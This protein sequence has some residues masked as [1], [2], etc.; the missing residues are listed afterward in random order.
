MA[1][2][3]A[4]TGIGGFD[5]VTGGGLPA[6]RVTVVVGGPGSGKTL[7]AL[8]TLV[9]GAA[10][11]EEP[12]LFVAFEESPEDVVANASGFGWDLGPDSGVEFLDAQLSQSVIQGG[13]FDLVGLLAILGLRVE[14]LGAKRVVF[15]GIDVLLALLGDPELVRRECF[16][17]RSWL[18]ESGLTGILTAKGDAASA[19]LSPEYDFLQ[20]MAD[21]VITLHQRISEG[22][23]L[24][25]IRVAKY[26]GS[27]HSGNEIP[28]VFAEQGIELAAEG[29][30]DLHH[31]APTERISTGIARLDHMLQGGYLRASS[32]LV[33]GAPGTAKTS[34][35]A[36]FVDAAAA[37]G[38]RALYVSFDEAPE[39]IVRNVASIGI[40]LRQWLDAGL[41]TMVSMRT[42]A[43]NPEFLV[44]RMRALLADTNAS[45]MVI[46][47]LSALSRAGGQAAAERAALAVL[48]YAKSLS[49]TVL[50][51]S[52]LGNQSPLVEETPIA[53]S[54][55]ADTWM[56][57]TYLNQGGERNRALT[58]IKSR[59]TSHSS[60]VRELLLTADGVTLADVY[61]VG[62]EVLMG[63]LRWEKENEAR[64]LSAMAARDADL[65]ERTAELA[66]RET[67]ARIEALLQEQLV[68][69]AE[70]DRVR[71]QRVDDERQHVRQSESVQVMR[72]ADP[73]D[74]RSS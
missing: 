66:L 3:R 2:E 51:T 55:I 59:G 14:Q 63:T 39:Q 42:L 70:L 49:V 57:V 4:P 20:F 74:G 7:F 18:R 47:P 69:E 65:R 73:P 60:Q 64:K 58:V 23:A 46:D 21:C 43:A 36:S 71:S 33:S 37:R 30:V 32:I 15:D 26:R 56:H 1:V 52:L 17:I 10:Q 8:Q 13:E 5:E 28:F 44:A 11:Y 68:R 34:I 31:P 12:G 22:T 40:G 29:G 50:S 61:T 25:A 54:T 16:R 48:D 62:G 41:L 35:A 72:R 53:V 6:G 9:S 38:E 67:R 27:A 19:A 24:R 45:V